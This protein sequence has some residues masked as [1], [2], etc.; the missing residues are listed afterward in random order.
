MFSKNKIYKSIENYSDNIKKLK[1]EIK[2]ADA[3]VIGAGAGLSTAAGYTYNG[4]RFDKYFSDFKEKYGIQDMYSGGFYPYPNMETFWGF[5]ARN[6]YVN[7]YDQPESEVYK[8]LLKLVYDKDYF[9]ITTNVDHQ[10]QLAGF[11]KKDC[12]ICKVIMDFGNAVG[13]AIK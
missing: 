5:W 13:H 9:V 1:E 4:D 7:R 3:I 10:F 6:I 8:N 2:N 12:S 11:D